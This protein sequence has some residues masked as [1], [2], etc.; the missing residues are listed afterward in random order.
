MKINWSLLNILHFR[1]VFFDD[2]V[3]FDDSF[4]PFVGE[5][6]F[7]IMPL[8]FPD[9]CSKRVKVKIT[10]STTVGKGLTLIFLG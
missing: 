10:S 8:L 7:L 5:I 4:L 6:L 3:D 9:F 1:N 2:L